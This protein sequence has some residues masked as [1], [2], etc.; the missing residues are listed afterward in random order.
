LYNS[1]FDFTRILLVPQGGFL[2][3][4]ALALPVGGVQLQYCHKSQP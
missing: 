1:S 3:P 4:Y 2:C